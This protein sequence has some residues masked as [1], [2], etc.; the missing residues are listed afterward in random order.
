VTDLFDPPIVQQAAPSSRSRSAASR[1]AAAKRRRQRRQR[2]AFVLV[3]VLGVVG[4][5]GYLVFDRMSDGLSGFTNP[6]ADEAEDYPGPGG[7][8][9]TVEIP[10]GATGTEMGSVLHEVGV[11]ASVQAFTEAFSEN[12]AAAGIQPG[13]YELQLEMKASDAV[14]RLVTGEKI[15][16]TVTIPEGFTVAQVLDRV[17]SVTT[18]PLDELEAALE[19]PKSVGLPAVA[20]GNAEGWLFPKTYTVQPNDDATA[21]LSAMIAQ[22][23]NELQSLGVAKDDWQNVLTKASLIEREAKFAPDRPM[24]ARAI[25]NRLE[26]G[27]RLEIDA[28]VAYGAGKSGTE[29]TNDDKANTGNPYNLYRHT[30]LPPTPIANPGAS[31]VE[32]VM[33]PADGDWLFWVAVNLDTGETK[34]ADTYDEHLRNV[35]ELRAWEAENS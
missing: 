2:S 3:L 11:V 22:T 31:S 15:E 14:S 19:K 34:F 12:P 35:A 30:G 32:A 6:F 24:M 17:A 9:V 7:E 16:T 27:Q 1:R 23:K 13:T 4:V 10:E 33:N 25:E 18:I 20:E 8:V 5:G 28:A 21:L 26:R 29:L